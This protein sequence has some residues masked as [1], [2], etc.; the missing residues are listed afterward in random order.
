MARLDE[1]DFQNWLRSA[2]ADVASAQAVLTEA[3]GTE[4]RQTQLFER[5]VTTRA[6]LDEVICPLLSPSATMTRSFSR[7]PIR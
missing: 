5:E 3:Q 6:R 1:Q 2:E 4:G 7:T